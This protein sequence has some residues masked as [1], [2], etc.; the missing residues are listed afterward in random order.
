MIRQYEATIVVT[1]ECSEDTNDVDIKQLRE[2]LEEFA[3]VE[4]LDDDGGSPLF[5]QERSPY[6][7]HALTGIEIDWDSLIEFE[8]S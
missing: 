3:T 4:C 2:L 1:V 8:Q 7:L 6:S 5:S